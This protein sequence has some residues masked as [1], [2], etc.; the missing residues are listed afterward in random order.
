MRYIADVSGH[1]FEI[2]V[3]EQ[4]GTLSVR[5]DGQPVVVDALCVDGRAVYSLLVEG[6]SY[7]LVVE[8]RGD[9]A[10]VSV[11]GEVFE[12]RLADPL[13]ARGAGR[14]VQPARAEVRAPMPGVIVAVTAAPGR[15]VKSGEPVVILEAMKMETALAAPIE[16]IVTAVAVEPRQTVPAGATLVVIER[17]S[18]PPSAPTG[19]QQ[20]AVNIGRTHD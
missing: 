5:V 4:R 13:T 16:G 10:R 1:A 15:A 7:E 11:G 2:D 17:A 20:G 3:R 9:T 12:V 19:P 6:R 18:P 14:A 8:R